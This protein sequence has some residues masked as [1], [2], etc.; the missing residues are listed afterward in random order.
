MET[1]SKTGIMGKK[2]EMPSL[3]EIHETGGFCWKCES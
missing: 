1:S 2:V 3:Q